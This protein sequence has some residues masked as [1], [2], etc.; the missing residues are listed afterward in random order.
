R[1]GHGRI[2]PLPT[3][4]RRV[5]GLDARRGEGEAAR[6]VET[7]DIFD[8]VS[9]GRHPAEIAAPAVLAALDIARLPSSTL[10][11]LDE[12]RGLVA[13]IADDGGPGR[14]GIVDDNPGAAGGGYHLYLYLDD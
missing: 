14:D 11:L 7:D 4:C 9:A 10:C 12:H 1:D 8:R 13:E 5:H 2:R 3:D 6:A